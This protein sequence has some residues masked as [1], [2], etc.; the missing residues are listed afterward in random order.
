[1]KWGIK[2]K[3]LFE[4]RII[5]FAEVRIII[6]NIIYYFSKRWMKWF[7]ILIAWILL[8]SII[9]YVE[10]EVLD[11]VIYLSNLNMIVFATGAVLI[12]FLLNFVFGLWH[13]LCVQKIREQPSWVYFTL[14]GLTVGPLVV[15]VLLLWVT[16]KFDYNFLIING[17][18][19]LVNLI[20]FNTIS[21]VTILFVSFLPKGRIHPYEKF[22]SGAVGVDDDELHFKESAINA[23]NGLMKIKDYVS[24]AGLFGGL[25]YGKSSYAR[26]IIESLKQDDILYTYISLTETNEARGFS[27]LFAERWLETLKERYPKI[28]TY[29]SLPLMKSVLRES[30]NGLVAE[31]F[32]IIP[33][34]NKGLIK[35]QAYYFDNYYKASKN[36]KTSSSVARL[37]GNVTEFKEDFWIIMVDE[38]ERAQFDEIYRLIEIVERFKNEGRT[39]LPI[40]VLFVLCIS[41]TDLERLL[42]N[43]EKIDPKSVLIKQFFYG[44]TKSYTTRI[45]LPPVKLERLR[46]FIISKMQGLDIIKK[47]NNPK[48]SEELNGVY[49]N[50]NFDPT[51]VFFRYE[52]T[53]AYVL[54]L[55]AQESPR[56][57]SVSIKNVDYSYHRY[58]NKLGEEPAIMNLHLSD[59][60][61][62]EYAKIKYPFI[63][64]FFSKTVELIS[65]N[66]KGFDELTKGEVL[67]YYSIPEDYK[68]GKLRLADWVSQVVN[69]EIPEDSKGNVESVIGL[70]CN[71]YYKLR[72]DRAFDYNNS[73]P[74]YY[75]SL[76]YPE[77]LYNWL[78]S[79]S[80]SVSFKITKYKEFYL[81]HRKG[82]L[83]LRDIDNVLFCG[84]S[85]FLRSISGVETSLYLDLVKEFSYRII[86]EK[87]DIENMN[88]GDTVYDSVVYQFIFQVMTVI[89][90]DYAKSKEF[91]DNIASAYDGLKKVLLSSNVT[92]GAKYMIL[93]SFINDTRGGSGIHARLISAF[94]AISKYRKEDFD[95]VIRKVFEE[96]EYKYFIYDA[97]IYDNEE[98]F[99]YVM[100]QG[101]SG[102][103]TN[104]D[105]IQK[106]RRV[107]KRGLEE[108]DDAI[109]LY[110]NRYDSKKDGL[111]IEEAI[112]NGNYLRSGIN[113]ELYMP[114][115]TLIEITEN[116]HIRDM[117]II[118][119][120]N[121]W[122]G[123]IDNQGY[124]ISAEIKNDPA[125]LKAV[126][127]KRGVIGR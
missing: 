122:K 27:K 123:A 126:L 82:Q 32:S 95:N 105:E 40:R 2:I 89:E 107:A 4:I 24:V 64:T 25:G 30:G 46:K 110:W 69:R 62:L 12:L 127:I 42:D 54:G 121:F 49:L 68:K 99:F 119:K 21:S 103:A 17:P 43:F 10:I 47:Y 60:V 102:D 6:E 113:F 16:G 37:F 71:T 100:Y 114:L 28:N 88:V 76:A 51:G 45:F 87:V 97:I 70:I 109:S 53:M 1:M 18:D 31:I 66:F 77:N 59:L 65:R 96:A 36:P 90:Q 57:I 67:S 20:K 83:K 98:N 5:M 61:A 35:T 78:S 73:D 15:I 85:N 112:D 26:M 116:S 117:N 13:G 22:A 86:E 125:T 3:D 124:I 29:I 39:G 34:L 108:R 56:L 14:Y 104:D 11:S 84:Y 23:A 80:D 63:V 120:M 58:R 94:E 48:I 9:L 75:N 118:D 7:W 101:W 52:D 92:V 79:V 19:N 74:E 115:K 44:D 111:T 81:M 91:S 93:N 106:I 8:G 41:E 38:I 33:G 55:L 72:N 50:S